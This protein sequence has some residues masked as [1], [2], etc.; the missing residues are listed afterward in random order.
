MNETSA[1]TSDTEEARGVNAANRSAVRY[2]AFSPS[3]IVTR[4]S[5]RT[6]LAS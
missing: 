5:K 1:T 4:G 6:G 2:L 3:T